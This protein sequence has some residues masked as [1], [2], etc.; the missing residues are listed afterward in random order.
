[1]ISGMLVIVSAIPYFIRTWQK[2]IEPNLVSWSI[3]SLIGLSVLLTYRD[4]GAQANVWP[5]VFGFTNPLIIVIMLLG[6]KEKRKK[7]TVIEWVCIVIAVV[8]FVMWFFMRTSPHLVQYALYL[9]LVADACGAIPTIN[10]VW[11]NPQ[12]ERPFAWN[13]FAVA[14]GMAIFAV[15]EP[16]VANYALP[17]Y[18]FVGASSVSIPLIL[19][20]WRNKI[21]LSEWI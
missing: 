15:P 1:M 3:W 20:R 18:M 21:P 5:A 19:Y 12:D 17:I 7:L 11:K 9:A 16:T 4:S 6:R 2:K 13:M 10:F 14:Y 8:S